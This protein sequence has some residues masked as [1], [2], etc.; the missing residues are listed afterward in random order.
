MNILRYENIEWSVP[1][2][3]N[4]Q[5]FF[6]NLS[7]VFR[8][9]EIPSPIKYVYGYIQN[10]WNGNEPGMEPVIDIAL[11]L[12]KISDLGAVPVI[13][14]SN[15][16]ISKEDLSDRFCNILLEYGINQNAQF[17]VSSD[18]L[19]DYI[20]NKYPDAKLVCSEIKSLYELEKG[21]E[22]D[23]YTNI[24][25]KYERITL[26]PHYVKQSFINDIQRYTDLSKFEVI[27]NNNCLISCDKFKEHNET[28]E[29][30]EMHKESYTDYN[31][32]CP[33]YKMNVIDGVS[34]TLILSHEELNNIINIGIKNIRL[35]GYCF[36]PIL[37]PEIISSYIFNPIGGYQHIS[38]MIDK[39]INPE[40]ISEK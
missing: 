31:K 8:K 14:F 1:F 34:K 30:F 4:N 12:K 19:Y 29:N 33:K 7:N 5:Y 11:T 32:L 10:I 35:N 40:Q 37:Y 27:A 9:L 22:F 20:K 21:N 38:I 28:V 39:C 6:E 15:Y 3:F 36:Q 18:I 26:S 17:I 23:F 25:D 24:Y 16:H 2:L 13:N